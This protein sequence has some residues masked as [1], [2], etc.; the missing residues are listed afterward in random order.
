M[1]YENLTNRFVVKTFLLTLQH[2]GSNLLILFYI[3]EAF[4][5]YSFTLKS[6]NF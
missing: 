2:Q 5:A 4:R 3:T 6:P 1:K